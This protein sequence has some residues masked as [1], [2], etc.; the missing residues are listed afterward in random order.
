MVPS[1]TLHKLCTGCKLDKLLASFSRNKNTRDG[2]QQHCKDCNAEYVRLN[3]ERI[4]RNHKIY[5]ANNIDLKRRQH[6]LYYAKSRDKVLAYHDKYRQA[7]R[8]SLCKKQSIYHKHR[9]KVDVTYRMVNSLRTRL[10]VAI[11]NNAKSGSA[12]RDLGCSIK[13]LKVYLESQFQ[14]GMTWNNWGRG[15]GNR[16]IDHIMPLAAFDLTNRQHVVLACH[17]GNLQPLWSEENISKGSKIP[18]FVKA[19]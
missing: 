5:R 15:S 16:N 19:A 10:K 18:V 13:E 14:P 9:I 4:S 7:N 12:V 1:V 2:L 17:Y 3:K 11:K 6:L 8:I